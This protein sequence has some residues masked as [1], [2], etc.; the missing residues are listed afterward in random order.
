[1][2]TISL[3]PLT[4]GTG[5]NHYACSFAMIEKDNVVIL[6]LT[7]DS[8]LLD[9]LRADEVY[10]FGNISFENIPGNEHIKR[11][12]TRFNNK[13]IRIA[14]HSSGNSINKY[15][16]TI[17]EFFIE[18]FKN[19]DFSY[20]IIYCPYLDISID[21]IAACSDYNV[22]F[23]NYT[24][25][26]GLALKNGFKELPLNKCG[27]LLSGAEDKNFSKEDFKEELNKSQIK[28]FGEIPYNFFFQLATIQKRV[29]LELNDKTLS[30]S[31]LKLW[32]WIKYNANSPSKAII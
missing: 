27:I 16:N 12:R 25:D 26:T 22:L 15:V 5:I 17:R 10:R 2:K 30:E 28:L 3:I 11:Y 32:Q 7:N 14:K 29:L 24:I 23:S 18:Q 31:V 21:N 13:L 1:M 9:M 8:I 4:R 6:D 20:L 19:E